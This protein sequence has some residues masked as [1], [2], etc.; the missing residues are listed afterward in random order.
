MQKS[1]RR[2]CTPAFFPAK[3]APVPPALSQLSTPVDEAGKSSLG[4]R[5]GRGAAS[6]FA[7]APALSPLPA[8]LSAGSDGRAIHHVVTMDPGLANNPP[9]SGFSAPACFPA[10][11]SPTSDASS[12]ICS[13]GDGQSSSLR[14][15]ILRLR[16]AF[17]FRQGFPKA[18]KYTHP[19]GRK[20]RNIREK[21]QSSR[22]WKMD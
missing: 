3:P 22:L 19:R 20:D 11:L 14:E 2:P 18:E 15:C 17:I 6:S 13:R 8:F 9:G 10:N 21:N 12:Q 16:L 1:C 7:V 5:P 4:L